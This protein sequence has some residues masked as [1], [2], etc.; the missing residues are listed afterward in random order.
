MTP[1]SNQPCRK[2]EPIRWCRTRLQLALFVTC[3]LLMGNG[4]RAECAAHDVL[5]RHLPRAG[6]VATAPVL[7]V[8]Q[9]QQQ[10]DSTNSEK[11][12]DK[13][14]GLRQRPDCAYCSFLV[15]LRTVVT[16]G[17]VTRFRVLK[18]V[19]IRTETSSGSRRLGL[20]AHLNRGYLPR[21]SFRR[22]D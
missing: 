15:L 7:R 20:L 14:A 6:N 11:P 9:L 8:P 18:L 17:T 2:T 3:I 1:I 16:T 10:K 13:M 12:G 19:A 5:Q 21:Y 4:A 22:N